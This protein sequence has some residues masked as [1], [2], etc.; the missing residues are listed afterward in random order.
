MIKWSVKTWQIMFRKRKD[1]GGLAGKL[2]E[3]KWL[4]LCAWSR[5]KF[6]VR[7]VSWGVWDM[8]WM[9]NKNS[10]FQSQNIKL[11]RL[12]PYENHPRE[13]RH[14]FRS[15]L[16]GGLGWGLRNHVGTKPG[17]IRRPTSKAGPHSPRFI[18]T[19][20]ER[21]TVLLITCPLEWDPMGFLFLTF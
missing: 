13:T 3:K 16:T 12:G 8:K 1:R 20:C 5:G 21:G 10:I 6:W 17:S 18:N 11:N 14:D 7:S 9:Q 2:Q 4:F 19:G 15:D